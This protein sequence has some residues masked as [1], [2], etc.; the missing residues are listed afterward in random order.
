[1]TRQLTFHSLQL[2]SFQ[3]QKT[4]LPFFFSLVHE[5]Q[6]ILLWPF[7]HHRL[8]KFLLSFPLPK[9]FFFHRIN[10]FIETELL[11][12]SMAISYIQLSAGATSSIIWFTGSLLRLSI[13]GF[14]HSF[15]SLASI[16]T[17]HIRFDCIRF[18]LGVLSLIFGCFVFS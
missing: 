14:D 13:I 7:H 3:C 9:H 2:I 10:S 11:V 6:G 18:A 17:L 8:R 12:S 1:M 5:P 15:I 16:T 4:P